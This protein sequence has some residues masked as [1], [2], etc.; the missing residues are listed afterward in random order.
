MVKRL[1]Y[2]LIGVVLGLMM[3]MGIFGNR[4][5]SCNYSPNA[6]VLSHLN[7]MHLQWNAEN[8]EMLA[9]IQRDTAFLRTFF[10]GGDVDFNR[11]VTRDAPCK[12]FV[13]E[14]PTEPFVAVVE[15]C[16]STVVLIDLSS[17]Q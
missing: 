14:H 2:Y 7:R 8:L 10:K 6:R 17:L 13:I 15:N 12:T 3:V 4:D 11:S 5:I 1:G 9:G 16:D